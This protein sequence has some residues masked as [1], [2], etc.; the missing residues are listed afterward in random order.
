MTFPSFISVVLSSIGSFRSSSMIDL[1][2]CSPSSTERQL[3][4][5][6]LSLLRALEQLSSQQYRPSPE[7]Q[8]CSFSS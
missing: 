6:F 4:S 7:V 1:A 3:P 2:S 5:A 8:E